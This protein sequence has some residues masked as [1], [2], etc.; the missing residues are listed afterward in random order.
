MVCSNCRNIM[1]GKLHKIKCIACNHEYEGDIIVHS[2][3]IMGEE[4][5]VPVLSGKCSRCGTHNL[6]RISAEGV[7]DK[8][9]EEVISYLPVK[10]QEITWIPGSLP[11]VP[12]SSPGQIIWTS[13]STTTWIDGSSYTGAIATTT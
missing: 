6:D 11:S 10:R 13:P 9:G 8:C 4:I 1:E 12:Y 5:F 3:K 2:V 7:C